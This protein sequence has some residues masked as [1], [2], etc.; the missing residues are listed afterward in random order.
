MQPADLLA[1]HALQC[2]VY[3][4]AYHE[5]PE[6]LASRLKHGPGLCFVAERA[7]HLAAYLLAHLWRGC[8]PALH[9]PLPAPIRPD[10]VFLHDLAVHPEFQGVSLGCSLLARLSAVVI[11]SDYAEMRLVALGSAVQFWQKHGFVANG[12]AVLPEAYGAAMAMTC[13]LPT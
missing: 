13:S 4:G 10:H 7:G 5:P 9:Q 12:A 11:L 3:P 1:V 8:L 6:A 2:L